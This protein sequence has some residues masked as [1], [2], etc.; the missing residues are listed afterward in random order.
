MVTKYV[1]YIKSQNRLVI[2]SIKEIYNHDY[3]LLYDTY[4]VDN[5]L[6]TRMAE[7]FCIGYILGNGN[8]LNDINEFF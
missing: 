7:S 8:V 1:Y 4:S 3:R 2:T 5:L 6:T